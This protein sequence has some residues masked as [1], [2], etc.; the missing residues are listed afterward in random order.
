MRWRTTRW[1]VGVTA[2][3]LLTTGCIGFDDRARPRVI[4]YGDSIAWE[5]RTGFDWELGRAEVIHANFP[6]TAICSYLDQ[7]ASDADRYR[8]AAVVLEFAGNTITPCIGGLTGQA[9]VDKYAADAEAA[10]AIFASRGIP[11]Y[12]VSAPLLPGWSFDPTP[13]LRAAYSGVAARWGGL[14]SYTDAG[15]SVLANGAYT[16]TLPCLSWEGAGHG[17]QGGQIVVRNPDRVHLCPVAGF[18]NPCPAHNSGGW[19]FGT[20]MAAPVRRDLG[21]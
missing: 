10:T 6:A 2:L 12:W 4:L 1:L 16:A 9:L 18:G 19:R 20:A 8:P 3:A 21:L 5:S 14:A 11:V 15:Q 7:M 17:C 13:G